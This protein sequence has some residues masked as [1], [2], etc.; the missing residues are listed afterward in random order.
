MNKEPSG[1]ASTSSST[2]EAPTLTLSDIMHFSPPP[3]DEDTVVQMRHRVLEMEAESQG[4]TQRERELADIVLQLTSPVASAST[5]KDG[6]LQLMNQAETISA[7]ISQR[8]KLIGEAEYNM[9]KLE[10]ERE[11]WLRTAEALVA[12]NSGHGRKRDASDV[13]RQCAAYESDNKSLREKLAATQLRLSSL[14]AELAK[15]RPLLL[16]RQSKVETDADNEPISVPTTIYGTS[17]YLTTGLLRSPLASNITL[18]PKGKGKEREVL[19]SVPE[20]G[21]VQTS[22]VRPAP[23]KKPRSNATKHLKYP[24]TLFSDAR[25]E[26]ILLAA[27]RLGRIRTNALS[28]MALNNDQVRQESTSALQ[29]GRLDDSTAHGVYTTPGALPQT[30]KGKGRRQSVLLASASPHAFTPAPFSASMT[31]N[32]ASPY[33]PW[34]GYGFYAPSVYGIGRGG[35][36][37]GLGVPA[38]PTSAK[39]V[40][41][42]TAG[43]SA[44]TTENHQNNVTGN[45]TSPT[46]GGATVEGSSTPKRTNEDVSSQKDNGDTTLASLLSA[47]RMMDTAPGDD[48]AAGDESREEAPI[49][50]N[51]RPQRAGRGQRKVDDKEKSAK[52]STSRRRND[53]AATKGKDG[54]MPPKIEKVQRVTTAGTGRSKRANTKKRQAE[55]VQLERPTKR[56]RVSAQT[57]TVRGP[58]P[59][60]QQ[61]DIDGDDDSLHSATVSNAS[62][63]GARLIASPPNVVVRDDGTDLADNGGSTRPIERVRS[64]LDV[65]ADQAS[66]AASE[67][68]TQRP[69]STSRSSSSRATGIADEEPRRPEHWVQRD[70]V[71]GDDD[72]E[73]SSARPVRAQRIRA[74]TAKERDRQEREAMKKPRG[75]GRRSLPS[76]PISER[77]SSRAG[78]GSRRARTSNATPRDLSPSKAGSADLTPPILGARM[79]SPSNHAGLLPAPPTHPSVSTDVAVAAQIDTS[80]G[81]EIESI[82]EGQIVVISPTQAGTPSSADEF[83]KAE[84]QG[85]DSPSITAGASITEGGSDGLSQDFVTGAA[86]GPE[87]NNG[88]EEDSA[89]PRRSPSP[90]ADEIPSQPVPRPFS[91][92]GVDASHVGESEDSSPP[93]AVAAEIETSPAQKILAIEPPTGGHSIDPENDIDVGEDAGDEDAEGEPEGDQD[94]F[95]DPVPI[96]ETAP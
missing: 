52:P 21:D 1:A 84:I 34:Y 39:T 47:A 91:P 54:Q 25:S 35:F 66:A 49:S 8:D 4:L 57:R 17:A 90:E 56:R 83:V 41:R 82:T 63:N 45:D 48:T 96:P 18:V 12:A 33:G 36:G 93:L 28:E 23:V 92:V 5:S 46:K 43:E 65:L 77:N 31:P 32:G 72:N 58:S 15:L 95:Y 20:D 3:S 30:P 85:D 16:M 38:S 86:P 87:T 6:H 51:T 24:S 75:R 10:S 13:E 50:I 26:H 40:G 89:V 55:Q 37:M 19:P 88:E 64:A 81:D 60:P 7:L 71:D 80:V 9:A 59:S 74:L 69:S 78:K 73:G 14:E 27:R 67:V 94:S 76:G 62:T 53:A 22:P 2:L 79:I 70:D 61:K 29:S 11:E 42:G 44:S 68:M